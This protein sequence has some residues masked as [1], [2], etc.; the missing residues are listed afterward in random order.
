MSEWLKDGLYY[1]YGEYDPFWIYMGWWLHA[2]SVDN[3][4]DDRKMENWE[5]GTWLNYERRLKALF[6]GV[7][8]PPFNS[9]RDPGSPNFR[10]DPYDYCRAFFRKYPAGVVCEVKDDGREFIKQESENLG[11]FLRIVRE[12]QLG[13]IAKAQEENEKENETVRDKKG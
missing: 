6:E 12:R 5:R 10:P 13:R 8:L 4:V 7:G 2:I 9:F 1:I 11:D 3:L